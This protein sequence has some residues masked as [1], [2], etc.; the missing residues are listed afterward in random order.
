LYD[1]VVLH[2]NYKPLA[3]AILVAPVIGQMLQGAGAA[4]K[5]GTHRLAQFG[6]N[7]PH[8]EDAWDKWLAQFKGLKDQPAAAFL[9]LYLDG[10]C[11]QWAL[12]RTKRFADA[13]F[14]VAISNKDSLKSA[15]SAAR[16]GW[17]DEVEQDLGPIWTDTVMRPI[18]FTWEE[19][20]AAAASKAD[21]LKGKPGSFLP[22]TGKNVV[23][24]AEEMVPLLRQ[25]PHV[26]EFVAPKKS[27]GKWQVP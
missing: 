27:S 25:E 24:S 26:E 11:S 2:H 20:Q 12:E 17:E 6:F 4:V 8:T 7:H 9:K 14:N 13:L 19:I 16:Y 5:G 22:R 10:I 15:E 18:L 3:Y 1:E 23:R 21:K